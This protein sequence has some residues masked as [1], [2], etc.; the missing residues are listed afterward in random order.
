MLAEIQASEELKG[1][2]IVV[3]TG[4]LNHEAI[5]KVQEF[6]VD[7]FLTK[8]VELKKFIGAVKSRRRSWFAEAAMPLLAAHAER[9]GCRQFVTW[10][11]SHARQFG[12]ADPQ[13]RLRPC[14]RTPTGCHLFL[15]HPIGV[16]RG[17]SS[18]N[19]GCAARP[20]LWS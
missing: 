9:F 13:K 14:L 5:L 10:S 16:R 3:L 15:W 1:I 7:G 20:R 8:P 18:P 12:G 17:P 2:P 19:P 11:A 6:H 4:S